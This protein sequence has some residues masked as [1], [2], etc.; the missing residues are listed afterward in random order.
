MA[1]PGG[2]RR[3]QPPA[4]AG[5]RRPLQGVL[6]RRRRH[7]LGR[8]R[9]PGAAGAAVRRAPQRP[10]GARRRARHRGQP[11]RRVERPDRAERPV[12]AAGDP[13]RRWPTPACA[14]S[15]V[16]AVEAHGTGTSLGDP[17]E[18]QALLATYGQDRD[19]PLWLGSVKSNIGHTQ[20]AAGVGRRDQD[21][22]GDAAR[23]AAADAAR[24]R[25][26]RPM[27]TGT[28][29][30][31]RL[32]TERGRLAGDRAA[33]PGRGLVVRRERHQRARDRRAGTRDEPARAEPAWSGAGAVGPLGTR[34]RRRCG[35][36]P[37]GCRDR[38]GRPSR[39]GRRRL[40]PG[41]RPGGARA[42]RG[43]DRHAR[44]DEL[45]RGLRRPRRRASPRPGER[46]AGSA[47]LF[48]GQGAQRLGMGRELYDALPRVRRGVRRG[49]RALRHRAGPAAGRRRLRRRRPAERDR[50]HPA[51]AV[52]GRGGA[53]PAAGV[54]GCAPGV[55]G[56]ALDRRAG[57]R[58]RRR[59]VLP[60][61]RVPA[62]RR[63]RSADAGAAAP[64]AGCSPSR[65][66]RTRS[67]RCSRTR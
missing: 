62:G 42:P 18:A 67:R 37:R 52:R 56:R 59:G 48:T 35:P 4:R 24:G 19:R 57:R 21:G 51:R 50:L 46:Q 40:V 32:L 63:A 38:R 27:W 11:G 25:A 15:D 33:A 55:P 45:L 7:R 29:G 61:G 43:G 10:P 16:D 2:V 36:R 6:R 54:L 41:H 49:V 23:R 47:F 22:A 13:R 17:I 1:T 65:P 66:P 9:R 64:A 8:G 28:S 34:P 58:A 39:A 26:R 44:R 3:V 20:A 31:V 30:D 60:G 12:A 53:V 5:R 14:P